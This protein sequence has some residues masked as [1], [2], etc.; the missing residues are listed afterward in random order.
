MNVGDIVKAL[1]DDEATAGVSAEDINSI[2]AA[3]LRTIG[4]GIAREGYVRLAGLGSFSVVR[5]APRK[6][7]NPYNGAVIPIPARQRVVFRPARKL[8]ERLLGQP[9]R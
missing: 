3:V 4:E 5:R 7:R 2:V 8:D 9:R 6:G 1:R